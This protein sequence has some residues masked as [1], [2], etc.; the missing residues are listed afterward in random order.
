ML[1]EEEAP[2]FAIIEK[3]RVLEIDSLMLPENAAAGLILSEDAAV[4]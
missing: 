2:K 3:I 4:G 1:E